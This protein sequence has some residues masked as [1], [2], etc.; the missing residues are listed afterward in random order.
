MLVATLRRAARIARPARQLA[1]SVNRVKPLGGSVTGVP[2]EHWLYDGTS[3]LRLNMLQPSPGANRPARRVGR[4]PGSG[5][6]KTAGKGHKGQGARG[7]VRLGF[8]GGQTPLYLRTPKVGFNGR[9][10]RLRLGLEFETLNVGQLQLWLDMGR[11]RPPAAEGADGGGPAMLTMR[12]LVSCGLLRT[13]RH[14]VKLLGEGAHLVRSPIHLEVSRAS[15]RAIAAI[16]A[17]G[18]TVTCAHY[19]RL[20]LRALLRPEKFAA[21]FDG[22]LQLPRRARPPPKL[23]KYYV[24]GARRGEFSPE[25]QKRNREL[26]LVKRGP[27]APSVLSATHSAPPPRAAARDAQD[28]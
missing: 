14:G 24:D 18:G 25:V 21:R 8:E 20:A 15:A 23:M 22:A 17:A 13:V 11:L 19:N 4:G 16:E 1:V 26:G 2:A 7:S 6:G 3:P 10:R 28:D 5:W 9:A 12:E 27:H